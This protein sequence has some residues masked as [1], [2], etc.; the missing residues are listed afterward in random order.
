VEIACSD[1]DIGFELIT[2]GRLTLDSYQSL[3]TLPTPEACL[4]L[5]SREF[6]SAYEGFIA[7]YQARELSFDETYYD[8]CVALSAAPCG[9]RVA[10]RP[11]DS[12]RP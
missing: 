5:P 7:A 11:H 10:R 8:L 3:G 12:W 2:L 4:F 6:L 9:A 1:G